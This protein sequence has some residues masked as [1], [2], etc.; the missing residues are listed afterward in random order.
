MHN[1]VTGCV[2][3][4]SNKMEYLEQLKKFYHKSYIFFN[5]SFQCNNK[6]VDENK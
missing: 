3:F 6:I 5:L 1:D 2:D 4:V